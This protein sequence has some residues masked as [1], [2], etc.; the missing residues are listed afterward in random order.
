MRTK[1]LKR[2]GVVLVAAALALAGCKGDTGPAGANG[3]DG[4]NGANGSNGTNGT[5]GTDG[6]NGNNGVNGVAG[7]LS[8]TIDGVVTAPVNGTNT[9]TITFTIRPAAAV[10]PG[11]VCND[12]L[13][14]L[15][16]KTFY[17]TSYDPATNTFPTKNTTGPLSFSFTGI[18]FKGF[19]ADGNGAQYTATRANPG[20]APETSA[21]AFVYGYITNNPAVPAP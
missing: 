20:F 10:C 18:H 17:A 3:A 14:I 13:S 11:A 1:L 12:T 2:S 4:T 8:L 9:A 15:G 19:T 6:T 16:Q 7:K 21:S 5:N